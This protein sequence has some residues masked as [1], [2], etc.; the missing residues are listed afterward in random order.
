MKPYYSRKWGCLFV[1]PDLDTKPMD[2]RTD[3]VNGH[4]YLPCILGLEGLM[5]LDS[6]LIVGLL[7]LNG[8]S[9]AMSQ[10]DPLDLFTIR[11]PGS[12]LV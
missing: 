8:S 2:V 6:S 3:T 10:R 5:D 7:V 9:G 11:C 4:G 1:W 12:V